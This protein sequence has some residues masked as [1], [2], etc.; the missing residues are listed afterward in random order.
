[1][2]MSIIML[3]VLIYFLVVAYHRAK[4]LEVNIEY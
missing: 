3:G 1:M 4:K 2:T